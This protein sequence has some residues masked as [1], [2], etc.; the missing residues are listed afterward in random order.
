MGRRR[1]TWKF[2]QGNGIESQ[3][4]RGAAIH[5][6]STNDPGYTIASN[7]VGPLPMRDRSDFVGIHNFDCR[8][9]ALIASRSHSIFY[10]FPTC[11]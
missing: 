9:L 8:Q 3:K 10:V 2:E 4:K 6:S 11:A 1:S 7:I 5:L